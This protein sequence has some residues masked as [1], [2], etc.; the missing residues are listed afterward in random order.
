MSS[1]CL[2]FDS[3]DAARMAMASVTDWAQFDDPLAEGARFE[4][5]HVTINDVEQIRPGKHVA[6]IHIVGH[7]YN[8]MIGRQD[9]FIAVPGWHV[10]LIGT[11]PASLTPYEVFP[12]TPRAVW[13]S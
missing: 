1:H 3:E 4:A 9:V 6:D 8:P 13:L 5:V 12:N 10:N 2:K 7:I 11:L